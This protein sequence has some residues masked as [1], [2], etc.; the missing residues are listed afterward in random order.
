MAGLRGGISVAGFAVAIKLMKYWY[1][2][3]QRVL[4]LQKENIASQLQLL[5]A[6]VHPHF[7]FNTL[8]NIYSHTQ[9]V[10]PTAST[11]VMGLSD[12]L[13]YILHEGSKQSVPLSREIKMM[14]DYITLE[15]IRYGNR[16]EINKE[17]PSE[18]NNLI[19]APL[20]LLP[21][22]ENCFK[23]GTSNMLEQAWIRL[24]IDLDG[25][26]LK[27]TLLNARVP[28]K[29]ENKP[30]SGIGISNVRKRLGLI[31]PGKHELIIREEEDVFIVKLM[32]ELEKDTSVKSTKMIPK[33]A[34][35]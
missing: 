30:V 29:D 6:Q 28:V 5:R 23:H 34:H 33:L 12:L 21:F 11:L 14:E 26:N 19:I 17:L 32:V 16:L 24:V 7:L 20:L 25:N 4:Q 8:N 27:M 9:K 13:R 2:K 1:V 31:Y 15:Q 22:I 18:T 3:E 35:A 10:A